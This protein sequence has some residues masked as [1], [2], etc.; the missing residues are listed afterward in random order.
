MRDAKKASTESTGGPT[1]SGVLGTVESTLG[2]AVGCEGMV[3]EGDARKGIGSEE[4][5]GTG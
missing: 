3:G 2:K 4:A 1:Q 5:S